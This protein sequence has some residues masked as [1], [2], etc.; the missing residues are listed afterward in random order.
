MSRAK[1]ECEA[2]KFSD[3]VSECVVGKS[4]KSK[5]EINSQGKN[6]WLLTEKEEEEEVVKRCKLE[7][8]KREE[9][10]E[11]KVINSFP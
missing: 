2:S 10:M 9:E 6:V 7:E 11:T 1:Q 5:C 8:G 3:C 4:D